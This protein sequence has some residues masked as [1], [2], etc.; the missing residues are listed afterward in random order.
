MAL[1]KKQTQKYKKNHSQDFPPVPSRVGVGAEM[2]GPASKGV[3]VG[4]LS[5]PD[6]SD[7]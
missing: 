1:T 4:M 3:E 7:R 2:A 5:L 6:I